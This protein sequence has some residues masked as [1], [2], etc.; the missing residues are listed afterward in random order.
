MVGE[1]LVESSDVEVVVVGDVWLESSPLADALGKVG[2][3]L[4][5]GTCLLAAP[6][7]FDISHAFSIYPAA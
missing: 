6:R 5:R 2:G 7:T 1:S 4:I 3:S